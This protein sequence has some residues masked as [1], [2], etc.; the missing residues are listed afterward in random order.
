MGC[1]WKN[2]ALP[3]HALGALAFLALSGQLVSTAY[4]QVEPFN[5]F[6]FAITC[7]NKDTNLVFYLSRVTEGGTATYVAS[8]RIAGTITLDGKAKAIGDVGGGSCVGKTL[9]ELRTSGQAL[10]I[11][12]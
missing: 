6:P 2:A 12:P 1:V 5:T 7:K 3:P 4:A 11:K 10:D 9:Q 8:D